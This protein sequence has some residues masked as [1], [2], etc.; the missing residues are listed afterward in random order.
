[1]VSFCKKVMMVVLGLMMVFGSLSGH[2]LF[3]GSTAYAASTDNWSQ[4]NNAG[5]EGAQ[6]ATLLNANETLYIVYADSNKGGKATV[7]KYNGADWESVGDEGFSESQIR[8]PSLAVSNGEPYVA[9]IHNESVVVKKYEGGSW[10]TVGTETDASNEVL[11]SLISISGKIYLAYARKVN[12]GMVSVNATVKEFQG[13]DWKLVLNASNSGKAI[14]NITLANQNGKLHVANVWPNFTQV[15]SLNGTDGSNPWWN[16]EEDYSIS[17]RNPIAFAASDYNDSTYMA[18]VDQNDKSIVVY[19]DT[20]GKK[21]SSL[22]SPGTSVNNEG[23]HALSMA[24]K[25]DIPYVA[26]IDSNS[27]K[28]TVKKY[29]GQWETVGSEAF[30]TSGVNGVSLTIVGGIPYAVATDSSGDSTVYKMVSTPPP[31]LSTT[32]T[33]SDVANAIDITFADDLTW[34]QNIT[35]VKDETNKELTYT[36][37]PGKITI[38]ANE[39]TA[40]GHTI[41]V[42]ATGYVDTSVTI[43]SNNVDLSSISLNSGP[44]N[45]TF[46]SA[47]T[48]YTQNVG[49]SVTNLTV[50]PTAADSK[51]TITVNGSPVRSGQASDAISLQIG[52][53]PITIIVTAQTGATKTYNIQVN[54][55]LVST[56]ANLSGLTVSSGSLN[57]AFDPDTTSYT[58]DVGSGTTSLKVT[59][60]TADSKSTV[61]VN[62]TA[63]ASGQESAEISL[64]AGSN[65]ITIIVTAEDSTTKTYTIE[66]QRQS[67]TPPPPSYYPVT[68]VSLDQEEL[69]LTEGG[70]TAELRATITPAYA[71]N[72]SVKWSSSDPEVASVDDKGVVTPLAG[73]KATITVT[74]VDQGKTA[75]I[76]VKVA[77]EGEK[78]LVGLSVSDKNI[79]LKPGKSS[80]IKLYAI[81]ADGTKEDITKNKEVRYETSEEEVA[82]AT[83]GVIKAG[84]NKGEATI[85]ISYQDEEITI[86]VVVSDVY[87]SRLKLIPSSLSLDVDEEEQL[88]LAATLSNRKTEDVTEQAIWDSS[89]PEVATV[90]EKGEIIGIAPGVT[91]ISAQYA[92]KT[93]KLTVYVG[94]AEL[95]SQL[96]ISNRSVTIS[97]GEEEEITATVYYQDR[98][99]KDI[100]DEA[101]WSSED[102][103]IATVENGVITGHAKGTTKLKVKYQG[104]SMT[105]FVK[106]TK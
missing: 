1:M 79:L 37:S 28:A 25:E 85:T 58:H 92:G 72:Q 81:Y 61:T 63:V 49:Q 29:I 26:Y 20:P 44:L 30:T 65:M 48:D 106:V 102:E 50:T 60:T 13:N 100:T 16:F 86:P 17:S 51:S 84:K 11:P 8:Y 57:E 31:V 99:K 21:S 22:S 23:T 94:G 78:R 101:I 93:S 64:T 40:V 34:R 33:S 38:Q 56:N 15:L 75:T 6:Y 14:A 104:K 46:D 4:V 5:I 47:K 95:I 43:V 3:A 45:E 97:E 89:E 70:E 77:R 54:K 24:V 52:S 69:Y 62:G 80:S 73:G 35:A 98:S 19:R 74:T 10:K 105:V 9:Y 18:I 32:A 39:L 36:A 2:A 83:K 88:T 90:N 91:V 53:N 96:Y 82:L 12:V 66:V 42:S 27:G 103:E 59:P 41:T 7:K 68:D 67:V 87:V 55:I 76:P 71:S